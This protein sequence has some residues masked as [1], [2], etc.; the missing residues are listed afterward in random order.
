MFP[1]FVT[2]S[3]QWLG[4]GRS[5]FCFAQFDDNDQ[6]RQLEA[7]GIICKTVTVNA[8]SL[9]TGAVG[10]GTVAVTGLTPQ[11]RCIVMGSAAPSVAVPVFG[12]RCATP[13]TLTVDFVNPSAGTLDL[14]SQTFTL[15]AIPGDL[16]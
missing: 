11:H 15:L 9:G 13:G 5:A 3:R 6:V 16:N 10:V 12:A 1:V 8:A 7:I 4:A 2:N 14:A